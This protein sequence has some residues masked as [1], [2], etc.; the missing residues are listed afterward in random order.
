MPA[1]FRVLARAPSLPSKTSA[2]SAASGPMFN[3]ALAGARAVALPSP[4]GAAAAP[5]PD[6]SLNTYLDKLMKFI[7]ADVVGLYL[8]GSG[9]IPDSQRGYLLV[10]GLFCLAAVVAERAYYTRDT[11]SSKPVQW[12]TV[13]VSTVAFVIWIY[14][15]GGP[16][17]AYLGNAYQPF[18]GSLLVLGWTFVVPMFYTPKD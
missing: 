8:V 3:P 15:L 14:S 6:T 10:W 1:P 11:S 13:V 2:I 17:K 16:F 5:A 4:S 12:G 7:P 9:I 18:V